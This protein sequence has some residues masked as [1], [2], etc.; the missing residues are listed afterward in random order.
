MNKLDEL[1]KLQNLK[2]KG[3]I[4][5]EE[6]EKE[7]KIIL[8]TTYSNIMNNNQETNKF[9]KK[10]KIIS[11]VFCIISSIIYIGALCYYWVVPTVSGYDIYR[12]TLL[13]S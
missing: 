12:E 7:K 4:T 1:E 2:D 5:E 11:I 10:Q 6:F 3:T 8:N 13:H 9:T